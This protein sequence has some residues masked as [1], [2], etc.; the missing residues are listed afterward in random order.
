M[1]INVIKSFLSALASFSYMM[2]TYVTVRLQKRTLHEEKE[3][4]TNLNLYENLFSRRLLPIQIH[5]NLFI[6]VNNAHK[7]FWKNLEFNC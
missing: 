6:N 1:T 7:V 5:N 2:E 3:R 4:N